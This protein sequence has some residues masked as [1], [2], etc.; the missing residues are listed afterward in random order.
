MFL[1]RSYFSNANAQTFECP[2]QFE[3]LFRLG[4]CSPKINTQYQSALHVWRISECYAN[5]FE[6]VPSSSVLEVAL[7]ALC[8]CL[9]SSRAT[10]A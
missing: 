2:S 6:F 4:M 5:E 7:R 1:L 3:Q 9:R 10:D 8:C